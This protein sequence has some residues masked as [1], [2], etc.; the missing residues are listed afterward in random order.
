[1]K[2][3]LL[4][5]AFVPLALASVTLADS[6]SYSSNLPYAK[7]D[8]ISTLELP[9]F[10]PALGTLTKVQLAVTGD[11]ST[12]LTITNNASTSSHGSAKTEV[13]IAVQDILGSFLVGPDILTPQT[14]YAYNL[15]AGESVTS[16]AL[17]KSKTDSQDITSSEVLSEFTGLGN[18]SLNAST[19]TQTLLANTGGN[20]AADQVT[21]ADITGLITYTFTPT[22]SIPEPASVGFVGLGVV[23]LL[24]RRRR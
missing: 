4:I 24:A 17:T 7:T 21:T 10:N 22:A 13:I 16:G 23:G 15:S 8:W 12:E 6:V 9:R 18:I 11:V 1:M 5:A 2:K 14:G 3:S 20:T 19:F